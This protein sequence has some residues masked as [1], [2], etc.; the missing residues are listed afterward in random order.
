MAIKGKKKSQSR[1]SQGVRR[2]AA[3]PK[4][5]VQARRKTSFWRTRDGLLIGGIF[6]VVAIG[7]VVWLIVSA[8]DRAK[9]LEQEQREIE[10]YTTSVGSAT[11]AANAPVGEMLAVTAVPETDEDLEALA[12]DA[13]QWI[14]DLQTAQAAVTQQFAPELMQP[15]NSMFSEAIGLY[16]TA[17]QTYKLVPDA[18]GKLRDDIFAQASAQLA[19]GNQVFGT[20]IDN[21][22]VIRAEKDIGAS[23]LRSPAEMP[24]ITSEPSAEPSPEETEASPADDTGGGGDDDSSKD[25]GKDGDAEGG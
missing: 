13:D 9:Q 5:T 6:V 1:G 4:P 8:Q 17:A 21:L 25:G 7:V 3:A 23:G 15:T 18:E 22:D 19:A 16:I 2:P 14:T 12:T 11:Q 20:A 24:P 10:T